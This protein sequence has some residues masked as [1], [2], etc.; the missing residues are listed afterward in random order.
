MESI[1]VVGYGPYMWNGYE[2]R[3]G[4]C[5]LQGSILSLCQRG[6]CLR[7]EVRYT[8]DMVFKHSQ[9]GDSDILRLET[10]ETPFIG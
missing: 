9:K 10:T 8:P 2:Q 5:W 4:K 7:K 1:D 3:K 6:D